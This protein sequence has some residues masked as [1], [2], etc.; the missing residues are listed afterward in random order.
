MMAKII[1]HNESKASNSEALSM[2]SNVMAMGFTSGENQYCWASHFHNLFTVIAR[3]SRG[4]TYSFDV[5]D[6]DDDS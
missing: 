2:V 5:L 3:R 6:K 1:I 4:E